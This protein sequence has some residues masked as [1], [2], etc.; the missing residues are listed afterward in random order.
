MI[1][2]Y[3]K[4]LAENLERKGVEAPTVYVRTSVSLNSRDP[5]P[6]INESVNLATVQYRRFAHND[7]I[8]LLD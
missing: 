2:Q 6:L 1:L 3:A 7:W 8:T 4:H 5:K